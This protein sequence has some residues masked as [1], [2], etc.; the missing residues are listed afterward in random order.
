M[1]EEETK[2][3]TNGKNVLKGA[4]YSGKGTSREGVKH[5]GKG[6]GLT[7]VEAAALIVLI[8]A[9]LYANTAI[10]KVLIN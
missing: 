2:A 10:S 7:T 5:G 3:K 6:H 8:C 9:L 1:E 4:R